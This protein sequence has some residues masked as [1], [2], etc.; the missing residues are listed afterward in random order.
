MEDIGAQPVQVGQERVDPGDEVGV[1]HRARLAGDDERLGDRVLG[2]PSLLQDLVGLLGLGG[3]G[4]V[5]VGREC[6][7][8]ERGSGCARS[9]EHE[10]PD[11]TVLHG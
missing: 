11:I 9:E 5:E 2:E 6:G 1:L 4:E 8:E 3:V 10:D 7:A